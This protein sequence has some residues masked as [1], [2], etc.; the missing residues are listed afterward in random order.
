MIDEMA[1]P[2]IIDFGMSGNNY[3]NNPVTDYYVGT[4]TGY[5]NGRRIILS[6]NFYAGLKNTADPECIV[7]SDIKTDED[8]VQEL[9]DKLK[10]FI[11]KNLILKKN[12]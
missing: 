8:W 3:S 5:V 12:K 10:R 2:V 7:N 11:D 6:N 1:N 4:I 9:C